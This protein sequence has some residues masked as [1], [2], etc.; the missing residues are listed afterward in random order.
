MKVSELEDNSVLTDRYYY[1]LSVTT[2]NS[3]N[4]GTS[5][6]ISF[7]LVGMLGET[8][9]LKLFDGKRVVYII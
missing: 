6:Q 4:A 3:R 5:S 9:V 2:G 8:G 1:L 7:L